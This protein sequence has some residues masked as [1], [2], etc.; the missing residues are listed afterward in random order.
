MMTPCFQAFHKTKFLKWAKSGK[1]NKEQ[2]YDV[3]KVFPRNKNGYIISAFKFYK[4]YLCVDNEL[5]YVGMFKKNK[6]Q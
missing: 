4:Q 5:Q 2:N 6:E 1:S 3:K